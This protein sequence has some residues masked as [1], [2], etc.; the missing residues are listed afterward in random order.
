[1]PK[2]IEISHKTIIFT[3]VLLLL[4][5]FIVQIGEIISWLF[6]SFIIMAAL[7]PLVDSLQK[8]RFPRVLAIILIYICVFI[9]FGFTVSSIVPPLITQTLHLT[10]SLPEYIRLVLPTFNLDPQNY[11]QQISS[12]GRNLVQLSV[13]IFNNIISLFTITVISFYLLL[14]R[15]NL[16]SYLNL[17]LGNASGG[18]ME[19]IFNKVEERLGFWVR[20]QLALLLSIGLLTYIGLLILQIPYALPLAIIAGLLEIVPT[21]GPIISSIPAIIVSFTVTSLHP[22]FTVILYFIIQQLENQVIVPLIMSRI[23]G[24]PPLVTILAILIGARIGG[25]GGAILAVPIVVTVETVFR[26]YYRI[27]S[28]IKKPAE[29]H[30]PDSV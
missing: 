8:Y 1:M 19:N 11:T 17:L 23:V 10:E 27:N 3:V 12:L 25:I 6:I 16:D 29:A 2:K 20:G 24:L 15:K 18:R 13:G 28:G 26:E 22:L 30:K 14:E 7:K 9:I 21:I 4:L 5:W